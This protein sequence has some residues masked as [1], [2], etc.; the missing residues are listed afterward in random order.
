M[1]K[2]TLINKI[3]DQN[4]CAVSDLPHTTKEN[5]LAIKNINNIQLI[6]VDTPGIGLLKEQKTRK[7]ISISRKTILSSDIAIFL[8][9][10][11]KNLKLDILP[12][13]KLNQQSIAL[14]TK[15]DKVSKNKLLPL[16]KQLHDNFQYI[17]AT[18]Y[19]QY[20]QELLDYLL[21]FA[22]E[23]DWL[24]PR[25]QF[26]DLDNEGIINLKTR[27]AIF[28]LFIQEVP[29]QII[30]ENILYEN[31]EHVINIQ[32]GIYVIRTSHKIMI[33]SKLKILNKLLSSLL[34]N[35]FRKKIKLLFYIKVCK[36]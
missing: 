3:I 13:V 10:A 32:Q 5:I 4:L 8:F 34:Y 20:P 6:F 30:T 31:Q 27:E 25:D 18:N 24:F 35:I 23:K 2:S 16:A 26:T 7:L 12:L 33:L 17:F 19:N 36:Y 29:H 11:H 21:P 9:E 28:R 15:T 14:I 22:K 1:G